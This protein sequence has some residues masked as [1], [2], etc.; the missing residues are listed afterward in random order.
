MRLF[1]RQGIVRYQTDINAQPTFLQKSP[2]DSAYIDLVVSPDPTV[3]AFAHKNAD[4][5]F[6]EAKTV[7]NAWGP[8]SGSTTRYLF[9]DINLLTAELT[10]GHTTLPPVYSGVSPASPATDQ[11]W[12][13]TLQNQLRVWS[14]T[15]WI[16]KIRVFAGVYS[17]S[18]I[19]KPFAIGSQAGIIAETEAGNLLLDVFNKPLR[20]SDGSFVTTKDSLSVVGVAT[21]KVKFET[22]VLNLMALEGI[23]RFSLVQVRPGRRCVLAKSTDRMSRVAGVSTED[24]FQGEVGCIV[25][26]GLLRSSSFLFPPA[27]VNRPVFCG[28]SGEL[29]TV[30]P[31]AGVLQQVGFVYDTDAVYFN[32]FPSITLDNPDDIILPPPPPPLGA[33]VA[34]FSALPLVTSGPA[35]LTVTFVSTSTNSPTLLEWDFTND[36]VVD[37]TAASP[38]FTYA[39]PGTYAV[40]LKATNGA[41]SS[42]EVKTGFITVAAAP[43]TGTFTNLE[44]KFDINGQPDTDFITIKRGSTF[45]VKMK[46]RNDGLLTATSVQRVFIVHDAQGNQVTISNLPPGA[47]QVRIGNQYTRVMFP[48]IPSMVAG[49][50]VD[51]VFDLMAPPTAKPIII[52]GA[53][54]SPEADS[55]TSDNTRSVTIQVKA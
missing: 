37:S 14:G 46:V 52:E 17:S 20:N 18:A 36:G 31:T 3:I 10:R 12:Y 44:V 30:P 43:P 49:S 40:R 32:I 7:R 24:L 15:K 39:S 53:V 1:F 28:P 5:V 23:P 9:W 25:S 29:T 6:E 11:H 38:S 48:A 42:E 13:D 22:E 26:A 55:T 47:T 19:L 51:T 35:P 54:S 8:F 45:Q 50:Q 41:G 2:L 16:D 33:P 21:K 4:Y 27:A 34:N